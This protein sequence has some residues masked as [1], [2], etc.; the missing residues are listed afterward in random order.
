MIDVR[1]VGTDPRFAVNYAERFADP[2]SAGTGVLF[3]A[4]KLYPILLEK[5]G[6]RAS[7]GDVFANAVLGAYRGRG[8]GKLGISSLP[9][10]ARE[11]EAAATNAIRK[12]SKAAQ[13]AKIV[14]AYKARPL[15]GIWA[16]APYLHNG[17]VPDIAEL[18]K[19]PAD[20]MKTFWI[21]SHDFDAVNLG[22]SVA[23][24]ADAFLFDTSQPG[25]SN[26]GHDYGTTLDHDHK[27][28]LIEFL[29]TL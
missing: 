1:S 10:T 20:R 24:A 22:L 28:A 5:F 19:A 17:S 21:G 12:F 2:D 16:T 15:N 23:K 14:A 8:P 3:G 11:N 26:Q 13:Q 9:A 29:K 25:N 27:K 4:F 18:L 6:Q 7:G